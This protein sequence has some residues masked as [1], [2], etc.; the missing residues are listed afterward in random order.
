MS[1]RPSPMTSPAATPMPRGQAR[2]PAPRE[3]HRRGF[4]GLGALGALALAG[5]AQ[6][7]D[8][9]GSAGPAATGSSGAASGAA[10]AT[11]FLDPTQV[12]AV[13]VT[14][15]AGALAQV[16]ATYLSSETKDWA[17]VSVSIDGSAYEQVGMRLKGNS[18]LRSISADAEPQTLPWLVRLDKFADGQ[19]HDGM[20]EFVIRSN[21]ST[22]AL[23]EAVAL[24][25]LAASGLAAQQ[26][27]YIALNINGS[28]SLRLTVENPNQEWVDRVF[29]TQGLLYKA[30]AS[31]DYTYRG[32]DPSAYEDVFDQETGEDDLTPLM[33]FLQFV[34]ESTDEDFEAQL[35]D[36]LD[37]A[38]F[39]RYLAFE[40]LVDNFDDI[41]GP[42]NNSY[43][44]WDAA[45]ERMTVVAW[46]HNLAFG[47]SPDG[48]GGGA[49]G[50]PGGGGTPPGAPGEMPTD[51]GGQGVLGQGVPGQAGPGQGGPGGQ[52]GA[53]PMGGRTNPLVTRFT[54]VAAWS[55]AVTDAGADLTAGLV[56]SGTAE[57]SLAR[58]QTLLTQQA[59]ELVDG[60]TV[61]TEADHIT[62]SLAS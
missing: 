27:A 58:W 43:L 46:D 53:G 39:A 29:A 52:G 37:V 7:S 49:G 55:Q 20:T 26:A 61:T 33:S 9:A 51:A 48:A 35:A 21:S 6:M 22:T 50:G 14:D 13:T 32:K 11:A 28:T 42:G 8:L 36:R 25:L 41:D 1:P 30:E 45:A 44:W 31:G 34:N 16:V 40:Q 23:N 47:L 5:C 4:L 19:N 10:G 17:T 57:Q 56:T 24:D 3:I 12:H 15:E 38:E 18:S 54:A 2:R 59:G 60:A 62:S